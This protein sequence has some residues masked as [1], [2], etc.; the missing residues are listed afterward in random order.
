MRE[1]DINRYVHE[2]LTGLGYSEPMLKSGVATAHGQRADLVIY[3]ESQPL[4]VVDFKTTESFP[5]VEDSTQLRFHPYVRQ[6]QSYATA[7]NAP[8]YLL[9][10][11]ESF[12]WF[13]TDSNGR[14]YL[15][16]E[17]IRPRHDF[18]IERSSFRPPKEFI[19]QTLKNLRD[20][21][22]R[23]SVSE[24]SN[25]AG[26]VILAKL[27]GEQGDMEMRHSLL[28]AR[29]DTDQPILISSLNISTKTFLKHSS[30][31]EAFWILDHVPLGKANPQDVLNAFDEIFLSSR[32]G[33]EF[34]IN[35]WLADFLVRLGQTRE[36]SALLDVF[37]SY[38]DV[39]AAAL[40]LPEQRRPSSAWGVSSN[41]ESALWA[42]IQQLV[43]GRQSDTIFEGNP[44]LYS[45]EDLKRIPP[46]THVITAPSFGL[47]VK[48]VDYSLSL[49]HHGIHQA[50][51]LYL[52]LAIR[53]VR[54]GG[55]VVILVPEG[56][57]FSANR[58]FT[59][60]LLYDETQI[61]AIISL[62]SGALLPYSGIK[63]SVLVLDK[64]RDAAPYD[65][66][67]SS[68]DNFT[69]KDSF[70]S[71]DIPQVARVLRDFDDWVAKRYVGADSKSWSVASG[72]LD[73]D[74]FTTNYYEPSRLSEV[75]RLEPQYQLVSLEQITR[76]NKR[77]T[78]IKLDEQGG[79]RVIG[80]A[81]IRPM[82]ID[83]SKLDLTSED[84]LPPNSFTVS[85]GDLVL[86]NIGTHLGAAAVV[87]EEAAGSYISRHVILITPD[88]A[89]VSAE[90][91][92]AALNSEIVKT[93]IRQRATGS[94]MPSLSIGRLAD[95]KIPL[96]DVETQQRIIETVE[97]ARDALLRAEEEFHKAE[98]HYAGLLQNLFIKG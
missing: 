96:P 66:L 57:L 39:L 13:R 88:S 70:D 26:I 33:R 52:E 71:K 46:P 72:D 23:K 15:L 75:G 5:G 47:K 80:P 74:N 1:E 17:P 24:L 84:K 18:K 35:R 7:L 42:K 83:V 94:V 85:A 81:A 21:L 63:S 48:K 53:W 67:M 27:L 76:R 44:L 41:F 77:G 95:I 32:G 91:L 20:L 45:A 51:D 43:L 28:N 10:D 40:M 14:P 90:Y 92:A 87:T 12:L 49:P 93:Q 6:L 54:P 9:T 16:N 60:R 3:E 64:K 55:R 56:L 58:R 68:V 89:V 98:S 62:P 11:G 36:D 78:G 79:L 97:R 73:L 50:E 38:G 61:T 69:S 86:N 29:Q 34:R 22:F 2:Y 37:G 25:E 31:E 82:V 19:F 65:I 59:R 8:Y 4:V 30:L